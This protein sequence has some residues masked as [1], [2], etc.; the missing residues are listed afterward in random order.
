M[1]QRNSQ[2]INF[3]VNIGG[4][5]IMFSHTV[6]CDEKQHE[7]CMQLS[8]IYSSLLTSVTCQSFLIHMNIIWIYV[9][10]CVWPAGHFAWQKLKH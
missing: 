4:F 6:A 9:I 3:V 1:I 8:D 7:R 2:V 10:S 5:L